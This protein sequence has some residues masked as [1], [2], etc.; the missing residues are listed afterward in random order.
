MVAALSIPLFA[1]TAQD[2][3]HRD[4]KMP[5]LKRYKDL[6]YAGPF[7]QGLQRFTVAPNIRLR[8]GPGL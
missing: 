7:G 8:S 6:D 2:L 1:A 5:L 3:T 4:A